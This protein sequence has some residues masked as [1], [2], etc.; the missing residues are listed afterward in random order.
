MMLNQL[1]WPEV[2]LGIAAALAILVIYDVAYVWPIHRRISVLTER[3]AGFERSLS[4]VLND[5]ATRVAAN[6]DRRRDDMGRLGERLGQIELATENRSYE[7]AIGCAE[8]GEETARL[9]SCFG[10]TE[11]EADLVMLLH[12]EASRRAA[13]DKFARRLIDTA[14]A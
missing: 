14:H 2:T 6:D 3:C 7:Q 1:P 11:G 12:G 4:T 13:V 9:I 8:R 5:L 10:L